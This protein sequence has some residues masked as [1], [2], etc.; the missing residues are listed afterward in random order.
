MKKLNILYE[1]NHIIVLEKPIN[2]LVQGDNTG[3]ITLSDMLKEYLKV[4]YNKDGNVYLGVI[5]RLDRPVGGLMVF[6]RTSKAAERLTN[7]IKNQPNL[8]RIIYVLQKEI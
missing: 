5:H 8:K 2:V 6:A 4:K 1:D 3:D 7:S